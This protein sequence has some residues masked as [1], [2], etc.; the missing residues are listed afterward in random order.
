[1]KRM[2]YVNNDCFMKKLFLVLALFLSSCTVYSQ[3]FD[4]VGAY[5]R[6]QQYNN[7]VMDQCMQQ[8]FGM[9][10]QIDAQQKKQASATAMIIPGSAAHHYG[11]FI[12]LNYYT[13]NDIKVT[14]I[15][16][17]DSSYVVNL[18][19]CLVAGPY[20]L[21][22]DILRPG[23]TLKIYHKTTGKKLQEEHLPSLNSSL[24]SNFVEKTN[25]NLALASSFLSPNGYSG[26]YNSGNSYQQGGQQHAGLVMERESVAL[27]MV[28]A[29]I[30]APMVPEL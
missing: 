18:S 20:L 6:M 25:S 27:V 5:Y 30:K 2:F 28:Q 13:L 15:D 17:D 29:I 11:V 9:M 22:P 24:Y 7:A 4:Y 8:I 23:Y 19:K 26:G 1:M 16:D 10:N 3:D 21:I 12:L 14:Y